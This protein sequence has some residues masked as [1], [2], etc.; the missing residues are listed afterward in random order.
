MV[1]RDLLI[2]MIVGVVVQLTRALNST[3]PGASPLVVAPSAFA[4]LSEVIHFIPRGLVGAAFL[5]LTV[6]TIVLVC[7]VLTRNLKVALVIGTVL[8]AAG[9][10]DSLH[11]PQWIRIPSAIFV[12]IFSITVLFRFGLL[13]IA[14][15]NFAYLTLTRLPIT[16]DTADWYFGRSLFGLLLLASIAAYG[17]VISLGGKRFM[18]EIAAEG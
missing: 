14:A 1:G 7:Q 13:A 2:G 9:A 6:A 16:L 12:A 18:P 5:P 4:D 3:V 15:S 17:F 8:L 10:L 11:G